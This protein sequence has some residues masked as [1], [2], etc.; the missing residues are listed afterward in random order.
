M[1]GFS[2]GGWLIVLYTNV[3]QMVEIASS[4]SNTL[5][6]HKSQSEAAKEEQRGR[7]LL[8]GKGENPVNRK[9]RAAETWTHYFSLRDAKDERALCLEINIFTLNINKFYIK[10][11][12]RSKGVIDQI[13]SYLIDKSI[14]FFN[15]M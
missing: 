15:I 8:G 14:L 6:K 2:C 1:D 9:F 5:K 4:S 11:E 10:T 13:Y 3:V 7:F 12:T